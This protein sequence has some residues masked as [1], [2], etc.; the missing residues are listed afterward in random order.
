M[1]NGNGK[2]TLD[3][4]IIFT[5]G[6]TNY[7]PGKTFRS[8]DK[9]YDSATQFRLPSWEISQEFCLDEEFKIRAMIS[10]G[11]KKRSMTLLLL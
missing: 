8:G 3:P 2:D 5:F 11:K 7:C 9:T 6:Q 4:V 10:K 1:T